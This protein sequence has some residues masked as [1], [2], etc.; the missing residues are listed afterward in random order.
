MAAKINA[1]KGIEVKFKLTK[2]DRVKI[3]LYNLTEPILLSTL[4]FTSSELIQL[5]TITYLAVC[6]FVLL[7]LLH[8]PH[9]TRIKVKIAF[10]YILLFYTI[11]WLGWKIWAYIVGNTRLKEKTNWADFMGVYYGNWAE[12][13]LIDVAM[14]LLTTLYIIFLQY[15]VLYQA[16]M[17]M[18]IR[19]SMPY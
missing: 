16:D 8:T 19:G 14:L 15:S 3:C 7:P 4:L 6:I 9:I 10:L 13:F 11:A 1:M 18:R 17:N 12:T 2:M 5:E